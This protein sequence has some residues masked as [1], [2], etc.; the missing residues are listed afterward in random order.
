MDIYIQIFDLVKIAIL[1]GTCIHISRLIYSRRAKKF[2]I[3]FKDDFVITT[4]YF[5]NN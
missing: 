4:E 1:S 3:K 2:S 5:D